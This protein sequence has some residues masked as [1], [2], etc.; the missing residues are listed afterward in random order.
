MKKQLSKT[1]ELLS[2]YGLSKDD[3]TEIND[4][5]VSWDIVDDDLL[6]LISDDGGTKTIRKLSNKQMNELL[7]THRFENRLNN[8]NKKS[9]IF[10]QGTI[11]DWAGVS[12]D[13]N[14]RG[15]VDGYINS[16]SILG[17]N[18]QNDYIEPY[19]FVCRHTMELM[20][21]SIIMLYQ[22]LNELS[23]DLPD[24]HFLDR[25]WTASFPIIYLYKKNDDI[26]LD[27]IAELICEYNSVDNGSF[28]FRYPVRKGNG[29]IRHEEY[30]KSFSLSHHKAIFNEV[31]GMLNK[32]LRRIELGIIFKPTNKILR[33]LASNR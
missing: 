1:F 20:L 14:W 11:D 2:E 6:I 9:K 22:E 4:G 17:D 29:Q 30:L 7:N 19:L 18:L 15:Y 25:L 12:R 23:N 13:T 28:Y 3:I 26:D 21:K 31:V 27:K 33:E 32:V 10:I 24:H 5:L 8:G 16:A